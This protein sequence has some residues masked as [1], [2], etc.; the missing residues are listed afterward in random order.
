MTQH[1]D[2]RALMENALRKIKR[3]NHELETLKDQQ[4]EAI[5]IVGNFH[6]QR[7]VDHR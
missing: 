7:L 6:I 1:N 5:A 2:S 3:L 4:H